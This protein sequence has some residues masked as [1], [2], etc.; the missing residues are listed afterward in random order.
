MLLHLFTA[1]VLLVA[2]LMVGALSALKASEVS[3]M[4][5]APAVRFER[6]SSVE[7]GAIAL[8]LGGAFAF[9]QIF[10]TL[11]RAPFPFCAAGP[12]RGMAHERSIETHLGFN[13]FS[14]YR[15]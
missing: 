11:F 13:G 9:H 6:E 12:W 7:A 3:A 4:L 15:R 10:S 14:P 8:I 2:A 5:T 1:G